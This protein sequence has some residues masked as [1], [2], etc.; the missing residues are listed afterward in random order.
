MA[1]HGGMRAFELILGELVALA[2]AQALVR[3]ELGIFHPDVLARINHPQ[4]VEG[5]FKTFRQLL[6]GQIHVGEGG[7]ATV[8]RHRTAG[9]GAHLANN[10]LTTQV[11]VFKLF[12]S[13]L[14]FSAFRKFCVAERMR[15]GSDLRPLLKY[16]ARAHG[17]HYQDIGKQNRRIKAEQNRRLACL[18]TKSLSSRRSVNLGAHPNDPL[19]P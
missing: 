4:T 19:E 15:Q 5:L 12:V 10:L 16:A 7:V 18:E 3:I 14:V 17:G 11:L 8:P 1:A 9:E 2:Q 6:V 13:N